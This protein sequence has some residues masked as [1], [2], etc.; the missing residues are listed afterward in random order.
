MNAVDVPYEEEYV[1]EI[2]GVAYCRPGHTH[3][4][5]DQM[6]VGSDGWS[7]F[8]HK[9]SRAP[10]DI[11]EVLGRVLP[12]KCSG[13]SFVRRQMRGALK[14]FPDDWSHGDDLSLAGILRVKESR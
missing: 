7:S 3:A 5:I 11:L 2:D 13:P 6:F 9:K 10:I 4:A 12:L 14:R 8:V 1:P